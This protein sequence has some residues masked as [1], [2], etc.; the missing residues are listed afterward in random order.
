MRLH[1]LAPAA[2][3][4]VQS[5][6]RELTLG[7]PC[8]FSETSRPTA[9]TGSLR[10][11]PPQ[12]VT[13]ATRQRMSRWLKCTVVACCVVLFG[14][15]QEPTLTVADGVTALESGDAP[16]AERIFT[17]LVA[18]QPDAGELRVHLALAQLANDR[19]DLAASSLRQALDLGQRPE[20]VQGLL[21]QALYGSG[22]KAGLDRLD[23]SSLDAE[24]A[25]RVDIWQ[26]LAR[27]EGG[28]DAP[29]E[30]VRAWVALFSRLDAAS[31]LPKASDASKSATT[32]QSVSV[33]GPAADFG[34][35]QKAI[36]TAIAR[37]PVLRL[38]ADQSRCVNTKPEAVVWS[39]SRPGP[40]ARVLHVGPTRA[41]KTPADA[42]GA[43]T[44]GDWIDIDVGEYR[45]GV[46]HFEQN[47]IT[48][49]GV[50]GRP[51]VTAA[52]KAIQERD[53]WMFSG[54]DITVENVEISGARAPKTRNGAAIRHIGS[55]L[56]LRHVLLRDS[57]NG[58]LVGNNHPA[59]NVSIEHSEFLRNGDGEGQAHNIYV[60]RVASLTLTFSHTQ[61]AKVG[62]LVK[63]R[64][65][66]S[67]IAFNYIEDGEHGNSSYAI[68]VPDGG[69]AYIVG[70]IIDRGT[71]SVNH[72]VVSYGAESRRFA[73]N[74]LWFLHNTLYNRHFR[75]IVVNNKIEADDVWLVNNLFAGAP[76]RLAEGKVQEHGTVSG[77]IHRL[78][79]PEH[80][81]YRLSFGA[82][83]TERAVSLE[84]LGLVSSQSAFPWLPL[85]EY[86]SSLQGRV[87][88][89]VGNPDVGALEQ[90]GIGS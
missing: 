32:E 71:Q 87:R 33:S 10:T 16:S 52:G 61:G 70:N 26:Q 20:M 4:G 72:F 90:C 7:H 56:A 22:A 64:A 34:A 5:A 85:R 77:A 37:L 73:T 39:P 58:L 68:D 53:V 80:G 30:S 75:A 42:A 69:E 36:A 86:V 47:G 8:D 31:A 62:H 84:A 60:G 29:D 66:R 82:P 46:A 54:D 17:Q 79:D 38:A 83:A 14:C 9:A 15:G 67:T 35:E 44:D 57:E 65:A 23:S 74:R 89:T 43:A 45:G 21:A 3:V 59:S 49:R 13:R 63:T 24:T 18:A 81:D 12:R 76:G 28:L 40:E 78:V 48:I 41:L 27:V 1:A 88:Q 19:P 2:V 25:L 51:H 6:W 50:G 55:N 11:F